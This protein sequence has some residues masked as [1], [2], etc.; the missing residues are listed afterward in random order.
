MSTITLFPNE[1]IYGRQVG[2]MFIYPEQMRLPCQDLDQQER[3]PVGGTFLITCYRLLFEGHGRGS[4][5][6]GTTS[7]LFDTI[8]ETR[9]TSALLRPQITINA[10]VTYEFSLFNI[11]QVE[12]ILHRLLGQPDMRNLQ[13]ARKF[14]AEELLP[15][16]GEN[17][18]LR[19]SARNI[20]SNSIVVPGTVLYLLS[21]YNLWLSLGNEF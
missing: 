11:N 3:Y 18:P 20:L 15:P 19:A 10:G 4:G 6:A 1:T 13:S 8:I 21:L 12:T 2:T 17:L 14:L 5:I 7:I 16:T 9:D